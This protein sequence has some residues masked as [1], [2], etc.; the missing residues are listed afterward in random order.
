[1]IGC[2]RSG[3][4]TDVR[5]ESGLISAGT[6]ILIGIGLLLGYLLLAVFNGDTAQFGKVPIPGKAT[7]KLP[8]G[9][10][11][12]YYAE[13]V[14]PDA[15]IPLITPD[16]LEYT[17]LDE[18]GVSVPVDSRGDEAKSTGD[19]LTRLIGAMQVSKEGIYTVETESTQ[20]QQRITPALTFGQGP[21]AAVKDRFDNV[22]DA[23][24][25]PIGILLLLALLILIF[26]PRY[27]RAKFRSS[28]K[29][30]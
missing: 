21:F 13:G 18:A 14:N 8:K 25:G 11:D 23:L 19:G 30:S 16:D 3:S 28:Y 26:I 4:R 10:V 9:D 29:D 24:K 6:V 15:G 27:R 20:T 12:I 17:I 22:V 5:G 1:M 2:M 7:V